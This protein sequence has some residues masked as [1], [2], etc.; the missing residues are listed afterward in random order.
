M[1][2]ESAKD[3]KLNH[4]VPLAR[5][6]ISYPDTASRLDSFVTS[7]ATPHQRFVVAG[8][9][10]I[11]TVVTI[12]LLPF[13]ETPMPHIPGFL[14]L[15]QALLVLVYGLTSWL[16][17]A[18]YD[19]IRAPSLLVLAA[20]SLY[21]TLI[22]ALQMA[23]FPNIFAPGLL[24]GQGSPTLLWLWNLWHVSVPVFATLYALV[25]SDRWVT[26]KASG[27][28]RQTAV[29][30]IVGVLGLFAISGIIVTRFVTYLPNVA[31]A[32][33]GY[34]SLTTSGVGP[35][36]ITMTGVALGI[37]CWR[38]QLRSTLQ[39][40]LAVCLYLLLLDNV[41]TYLGAA[42]ETM[43]WFVGR[44]EALLSAFV[45]LAVYLK[46]IDHLYRRAEDIA[47][48]REEAR[49]E[50]Q[51]ARRNLE[52]AL[53]ASGMG[54]WELDLIGHRTRR[55]LRHDRL[56]GYTE[57]QQAWS[58]QHFL[59]HV[60][61]EDKELAQA[62]FSQALATGKLVLECR[63]QRVDDQSIRWLALHGRTSVDVHGKPISMAGCVMDV[64]D[65][66]L[67]DERLR[68]AERMEAIGQLTGGVAHD[69]NNLLTIMLGSLD[70]IA[71]RT[72]DP[73]RVERLATNALSAG[74]RGVDLTDKLLAFAR[75]SVTQDETANV[76]RLITDFFPLLQQALGE[77]VNIELHLDPNLDPALLDQQQFQAALLNLAG[78]SRDA[79][80]SGGTLTI[81][82]QNTL[83]TASD[84]ANITE[85]KTGRF[86]KISIA[87]T[88]IGMHPHTIGR[89]FEPF[90]TTKDVGKGTGLGLSQ[91]YG[92]AQQAGGFCRIKSAP[93]EGCVVEIYLPRSADAIALAHERANTVPLKRAVNGEVVLIVEDEEAVREIAS[94]SLQ[95]LGYGV[96]IA[97]DARIALD[98]LR[99]PTR[100]DVLFSDIVMPGG[101]NGAQLANE[102]RRIKP[103]LKVLLTS[104]YIA[105]ATG[106][107]REL[108]EGVPLLRKPYMREDLAAKLQAIMSA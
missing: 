33:G 83:V 61:P 108:P 48:A 70:M 45:V 76:N 14:I 98:I 95:A 30:A 40:C 55:N 86:L 59:D 24:I 81:T 43:G 92:F 34:W 38:T 23:S 66:R 64:T 87:D 75:R 50:A 94:E 49:L 73:Q 37:L 35:V 74:R 104:G 85:G 89:A 107:V 47:E 11:L 20:G 46:E 82:T 78:N 41:I 1:F 57:L 10:A 60:V 13:A 62:A 21:T 2:A 27:P 42:R 102:A 3:L 25:D 105:T 54:D 67:T 6:G 7:R 17:L 44:L 97:P 52:V 77:A 101:M 99:S 106:G 51:L 8:L 5:N 19:R 63:I 32:N 28:A 91:V 84:L 93:G 80:P 58:W 18:Q 9:C 22:V 16:L 79:M 71:R 103:T 15:N 31:D 29:I 53:E 69:F 65:R 56:F 90:Y 36:I 39:L 96:L 12:A 100:V 26:P 4:F 68:R 88:G 72:T